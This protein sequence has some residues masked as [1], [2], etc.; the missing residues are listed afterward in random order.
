[1]KHPSFEILE[2]TEKYSMPQQSAI[3][4]LSS[5]ILFSLGECDAGAFADAIA[6]IRLGI[7]EDNQQ[8][9]AAL[10]AWQD[11]FNQAI[12]AE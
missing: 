7:P 8:A 4:L 1:M 11:E 9:I 2:I 6:H 10:V 5:A 3:Q 12:P